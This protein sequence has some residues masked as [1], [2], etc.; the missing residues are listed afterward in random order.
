MDT[1]KNFAN[2][3]ANRDQNNNNTNGKVVPYE[4]KDKE[5]LTVKRPL[6]R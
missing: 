5:P 4:E 1:I 3:I 6:I 2:N